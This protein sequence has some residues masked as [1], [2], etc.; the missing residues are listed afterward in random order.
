MKEPAQDKILLVQS[1]RIEVLL[2]LFIR[3]L[4]T[5]TLEET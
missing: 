1:G 3:C 2:Q 5:K 4:Q